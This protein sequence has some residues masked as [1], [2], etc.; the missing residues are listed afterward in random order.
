MVRR[1]LKKAYSPVSGKTF[2]PD[3]TVEVSEAHA[4][5]LEVAGFLVPLKAPKE[6]I[7][8]V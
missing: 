4:A 1:K 5:A 7:E 8:K 6:K 3:G 2:Y